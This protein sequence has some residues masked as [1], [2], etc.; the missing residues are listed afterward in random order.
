VAQH[1]QQFGRALTGGYRLVR[2]TT[3]GIAHRSVSSLHLDHGFHF[4][5]IFLSRER[6]MPPAI[7]GAFWVHRIQKPTR[8][9]ENADATNEPTVPGSFACVSTAHQ[10]MHRL[11][12][13]SPDSSAFR[14]AEVAHLF[15]PLTLIRKS[16]VFRMDCDYG[17][18]S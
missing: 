5:P 10:P 1:G 16:F 11:Y 17:L 2:A 18:S 8:I 3:A 13:N 9:A 6:A 14:H 15:G 4:F 7:P 12:G